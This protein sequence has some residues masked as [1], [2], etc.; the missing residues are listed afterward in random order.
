MS[1]EL[2]GSQAATMFLVLMRCA[3]F[4]IT[5]PL[6][7]HRG[8]PMPIKAGLAVAL[9]VALAA[10]AGSTPGAA[11]VLLAVPIELGIGVALGFIL[12]LGFH[13]V[14]MTGRLISLQTGLSLEAVLSPTGGNE[15]ATALD[16]LFALLAGLLFLALDV[17]L[18]MVGVI[19]RSF[20]AFPLGAGWPGSVWLAAV[21]LSTLLLEIG[22][23]IALPLALVLLL[24]ELAMALV[25]RAI[26]QLNVF[27]LSLPL[28]L[29]LGIVLLIAS[30][31]ALAAGTGNAYGTIVSAL[32]GG[33]VP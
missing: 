15:G 9:T 13:A 27:V 4:V 10:R 28:K 1:Y 30:L 12:S 21:Q 14:E 16:P 2:A 18:A 32:D 29:T 11:P 3:G 5:A 17:H 33:M 22:V 7:G 8:V 20:E 25:A 31:P 19:A 23:R 24:A 6:L 26:P